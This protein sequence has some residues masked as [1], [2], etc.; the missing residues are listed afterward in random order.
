MIDPDIY[1]QKYF[2]ESALF[3]NVQIYLTHEVVYFR[4][5]LGIV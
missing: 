4:I 5:I 1:G 3:R 2:T